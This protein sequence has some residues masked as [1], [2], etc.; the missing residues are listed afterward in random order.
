VK[1]PLPALRC[2]PV[3]F[4]IARQAGRWREL[5]RAAGRDLS[6]PGALIGATALL[7]DISLV[8]DNKKDFPLPGL[9]FAAP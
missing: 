7:R 5:F 9:R 3:T 6:L 2:I 1:S 4:E 8:T